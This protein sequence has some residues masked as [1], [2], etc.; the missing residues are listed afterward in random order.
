MEDELAELTNSPMLLQI[1]EQLVLTFPRKLS[2]VIFLCP[3]QTVKVTALLEAVS[4]AVSV[5]PCATIVH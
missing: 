1:S 4:C 5:L 3:Y 2:T